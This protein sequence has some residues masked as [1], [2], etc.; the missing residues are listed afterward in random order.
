MTKDELYIIPYNA[1]EVKQELT[2]YIVR[3]EV[4]GEPPKTY[5]VNKN[6]FLEIQEK[7]KPYRSKQQ[8][9][10]MVRCIETGKIFKN[11][12]AANLWLISEG[13]TSNYHADIA[14][15]QVCKGKKESACGYHW[16]FT[17]LLI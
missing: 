8:L 2:P 11:A 1:I 17:G 16:R 14:I 5:R 15:K 6:L 7:V 9:S 10:K 12:K 4:A 13:I 3:L